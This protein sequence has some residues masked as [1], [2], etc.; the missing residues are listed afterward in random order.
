MVGVLMVALPAHNET[1][2]QWAWLHGALAG[3]MA[4]ATSLPRYWVPVLLL[5]APAAVL[6]LSLDLPPLLWLGA[7]LLLWLVFRGVIRDRVPLFLS[8]GPATR[9]LLELI[10][11]DRPVSVVDLGCGTGGLLLALREARTIARLR[12][13]ENAPLTWLVAR[14]RLENAAVDVAFGSIWDERLDHYDVVYAYLS[15]AAMPRL[16]DKARLEMKPGSLLVSNSFAVP[17]V[18]AQ[19]VIPLEGKGVATALYVWE[20]EGSPTPP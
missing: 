19:R 13:V 5:F 11:D 4:W 12:G 14:L 8:D 10:P 6:A 1:L 16:W 7:G 2:L 15:P 17:G 20:M 3:S 9:R 18:A